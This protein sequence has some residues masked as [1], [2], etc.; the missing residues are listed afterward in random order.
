MFAAGPR[1]TDSGRAAAAGA[2]AARC[3]GSHQPRC[4]PVR[5][6]LQVAGVRAPRGWAANHVRAQAYL[7]GRQM[8]LQAR[9]VTALDQVRAQA[10]P[11]A[12]RGLQEVEGGS[13]EQTAVSRGGGVTLALRPGVLP[14]RQY[15]RTPLPALSRPEGSWALLLL[16]HITAEGRQHRRWRRFQATP[17]VTWPWRGPLHPLQH[18]PNPVPCLQPHCRCRSH[19][20]RRPRECVTH[21]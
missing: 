16:P 2:A 3:G 5:R 14:A 1:H 17:S 12:E 9:W 11:Q 21:S 10:G 13:A 19:Q 7:W 6:E 15:P 18:P 20:P 4:Q 8:G